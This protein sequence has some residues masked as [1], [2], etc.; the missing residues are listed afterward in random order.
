MAKGLLLVGRIYYYQ[1]KLPSAAVQKL[2][3][4]IYKRSLE[5]DSL[6]QA[7]KYVTKLNEVYKAIFKELK[8]PITAY[9]DYTREDMIKLFNVEFYKVIDQDNKRSLAVLENKYLTKKNS[10]K[11]ISTLIN[12]YV[13]YLEDV[14]HLKPNTI[15]AVESSLKTV[16]SQDLN[17][18]IED[19]TTDKITEILNNLQEKRTAGTVKEYITKIKTFFRWIEDS[20]DI[21]IDRTIYKVVSDI[22]IGIKSE[23]IRDAFTLD[24]LKLLFGVKYIQWF[25]TAY[26][27]F[28]VL[29]GYLCGLRIDEA[30]SLKVKDVTPYKDQFVL[31]IR[32]GK[33]DNAKRYVITPKILNKFGLKY[34]I[35]KLLKTNPNSESSLWQTPVRTTT[36][37]TKFTEYLLSLKIKE[38]PKDRRYTE[39]SLRHSFATKLIAASVD[40]RFAK[41]YVGHSG[42][43]LMTSRYLIQIPEIEDI[44]AHIDSKLDFSYEL[45]DLVP[46]NNAEMILEQIKSFSYNQFDLDLCGTTEERLEQLIKES[47]QKNLEQI[48]EEFGVRDS[49][50][51]IVL[52]EVYKRKYMK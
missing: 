11:H 2:G 12:L 44:I 9:D 50:K 34:Y 31:Q 49:L 39:H 38:N 27:Y 8:R 47:Y 48:I 51:K 46:F 52:Y 3:M 13:S 1:K 28:P 32:E 25:K 36:L 43:S 19:I 40:D 7:E 16:F 45:S 41:K 5:T 37:S 17:K 20:E 22:N 18:T 4:K 15:T 14:K 6:T 35:D 23:Q 42:S 30:N 33:T 21:T 29:L 26:T 10:Y 24:Q